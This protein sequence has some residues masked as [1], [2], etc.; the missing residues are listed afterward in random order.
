[1][2]SPPP[3]SSSPPGEQSGRRGAGTE[4]LST[5]DFGKPRSALVEGR[6]TRRGVTERDFSPRGGELKRTSGKARAIGCL[7]SCIVLLPLVLFRLQEVKL[8]WR[9][10]RYFGVGEMPQT[11]SLPFLP[12]LPLQTHGYL[13]A[14]DVSLLPSLCLLG[15]VMVFLTG[16]NCGSGGEAA[17]T[18]AGRGTRATHCWPA[19][20]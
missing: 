15:L 2:H 9:P 16:K 10:E 19:E 14:W 6:N 8:F 7:V 17:G 12:T 18:D 4:L 11:A 1:M 3:P 20:L 13:S 5:C